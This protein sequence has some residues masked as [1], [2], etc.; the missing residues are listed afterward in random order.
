MEVESSGGSGDFCAASFAACA[1][2][3]SLVQ[4]APVIAAAAPI[5]ALRMRNVRRSM[6]SGRFSSEEN[7]GNGL[8]FLSDDFLLMVVVLGVFPRVSVQFL[9]CSDILRFGL[10]RCNP[11]RQSSRWR[12]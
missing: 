5:T 4:T 8:S 9:S 3:P 7:S 10:R 1:A 6:F 2:R 11:S 12:H